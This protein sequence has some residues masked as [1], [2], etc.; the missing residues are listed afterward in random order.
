MRYAA[1]LDY[2]TKGDARARFGVDSSSLLMRDIFEEQ[3][4]GRPGSVAFF[5]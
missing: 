5:L 2:V 1:Q 4:A 3:L